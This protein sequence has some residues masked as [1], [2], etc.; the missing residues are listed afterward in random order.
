MPRGRN[1]PN[2]RSSQVCSVLV[3][4]PP[5][6]GDPAG[7]CARV[8]CEWME[9]LLTRLVAA[10]TTQQA[11][12]D[13]DDLTASTR[14]LIEHVAPYQTVCN[15]ANY[16]FNGLSGVFSAGVPGGTAFNSLLNSANREQDNRV[17]DF[18][19]DRPAGPRPRPGHGRGGTGVDAA[20]LGAAR[21]GAAAAAP[22]GGRVA[23][24]TSPTRADE[25]ADSR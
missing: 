8:R 18:P 14:P 20:R 4:P 25:G 13:L 24:G 23:R 6:P 22:A 10:P 1:D 15:Y 2:A 11:L 16:Y 7:A 12:D 5:G 3:L 19:S 9:D 21:A 17:S